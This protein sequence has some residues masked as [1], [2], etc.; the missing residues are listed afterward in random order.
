M[1]ENA[2]R[3]VGLPLNGPRHAVAL[4]HFWYDHFVWSVRKRQVAEA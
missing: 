4:M 2:V 1:A 3:T